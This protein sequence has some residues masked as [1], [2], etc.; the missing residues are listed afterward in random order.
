MLAQTAQL[1]VVAPGTC[2]CGLHQPKKGK[3]E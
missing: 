2:I 3:I 1:G